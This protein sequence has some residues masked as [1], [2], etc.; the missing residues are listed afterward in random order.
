MERE[1]DIALRF[2]G[3]SELRISVEKSGEIIV[4]FRGSLPIKVTGLAGR[5]DEL[6]GDAMGIINPEPKPVA[7]EVVNDSGVPVVRS[8][9]E[10]TQLAV[11]ED[12]D[13]ESYSVSDEWMNQAHKRLQARVEE[14]GGGLTIGEENYQRVRRMAKR[15][16]EELEQLNRRAPGPQGRTGMFS[17][18]RVH[19]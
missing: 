16:E 12:R 15:A 5:G 1:K 18:L 3:V 11:T 7:P 14:V 4:S 13:T 17:G 10:S 8:E 19:R 2:S 6:S 9:A